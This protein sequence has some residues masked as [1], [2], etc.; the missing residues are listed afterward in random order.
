MTR[1]GSVATSYQ[2]E[3]NETTDR[4]K[5]RISY[6]AHEGPEVIRG[7]HVCLYAVREASQGTPVFVVTSKFLDRAT[8][9]D[10]LKA[11]HHRYARVGFQRKSPQNNYRRLIATAIPAGRFLL[12]SV[13]YVPSHK[14]QVPLTVLLGVLNSRLSD[15]YFRLGST[16]AMVGEYQFNN[17]PFPEFSKTEDDA[18]TQL[19]QGSIEAINR[20]QTEL[21]WETAVPLIETSPFPLE[22]QLLISAAVLRIEA[23]ESDRGEIRRVERS[24]LDP[25]AQPFQ[26]FID[27][28]LYRMAGI[29]DNEA[30]ELEG[31]LEKMM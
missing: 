3:I 28:L 15:W 4:K 24:A 22:I 11:F 2:G 19:L 27:R 23:I 31:R 16:N 7:A 26:D 6:S 21:A 10:D 12:E 5:G 14:C 13:S 9:G 18:A 17:L 29:A 8:T 1:L 20:G 25:S 30:K